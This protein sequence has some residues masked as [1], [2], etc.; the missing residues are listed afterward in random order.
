M[1]CISLVITQFAFNHKLNESL[2]WKDKIL[3]NRKS[4]RQL[5]FDFIDSIRYQGI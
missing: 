5:A 1:M 3:T 2:F 4:L